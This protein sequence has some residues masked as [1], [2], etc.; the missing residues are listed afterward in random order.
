MKSML[1]R[2][3]LLV[4][5]IHDRP[6]VGVR[7]A[8]TVDG[9]TEHVSCFE[10]IL[11]DVWA[12]I[13]FAT[14]NEPLEYRD[15]QDDRESRNTV[16]HVVTRDRQDGWEHEEDCG[17]DGI[18]DADLEM[19]AGGKRDPRGMTYQIADPAGWSWQNKGSCLW[20]HLPASE[21]VD[22]RWNSICDT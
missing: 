14:V 12:T 15:D 5:T 1:L 2:R 9:H 20:Q 17:Q 19:S 7:F 6:T 4:F 3:Q 16:V 21:A 8:M 10:S 18:C 22:S 11:V 13:V